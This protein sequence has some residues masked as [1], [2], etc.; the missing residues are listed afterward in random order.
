MPP[1]HL[2]LRL[3]ATRHAWRTII[4]PPALPGV[5]TNSFCI[6]ATVFAPGTIEALVKL[7]L[8]SLN[9]WTVPLA[10]LG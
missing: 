5:L 8:G 7:A 1:Q 4:K 9:L 6:A 2:R 3:R 10:T